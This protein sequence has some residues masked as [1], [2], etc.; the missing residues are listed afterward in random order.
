MSQSSYKLSCTSCCKQ[1]ADCG[2]KLRSPAAAKHLVH[3][4]Q[5]LL[6]YALIPSAAFTLRSYLLLEHNE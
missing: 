5:K 2:K 4:C 6:I 1:T 3:E